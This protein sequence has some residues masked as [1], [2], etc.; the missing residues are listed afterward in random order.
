MFGIIAPIVGAAV[1]I[2]GANKQANA[3]REAQQTRNDATAAQYEYDKEKWAM[4][5]QQMLANREFKVR[6]IEERARAEGELA[7]FKD[8]SAARQYNYQL[9][10]R[11]KQ[12]DTNERMYA[13]SNAIFQSQLGL[14]AL[15]ERSARMDERQQL[16]EIKAEKRYEKNTAYLDGI[17]AEGEIRARGQMGRSVAKARSVQTLKTATALTLLDLS[18]QNA[19]TASESA[20]RNIKQDRTVADLNAFASKMLDPGVLPM[21][22]QPLPTP[23][24]QFMYPRTY[25][26]YDFGPQPIQGA[27]ISP[28]SAAAQVWGSSIT[29]LAGAA[30]QIVSGFTPNVT[31]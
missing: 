1:G 22:V 31:G 5:K 10:I 28:N 26:D 7:G 12:Q 13:K 9:Q 8:A 21:P 19:T 18:L 15:Q 16:E 11:D 30:S 14:N 20:I 17:I 2:Y 27:M 24:A 4:D 23:M 25:E 6:E 29:S 3:Q